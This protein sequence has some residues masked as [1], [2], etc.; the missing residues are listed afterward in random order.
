MNGLNRICKKLKIDC[1]PAVIGFDFHSGSSHPVYDG[2]VVCEEFAEIVTNAWVEEQEE[3]ERKEKEKYEERVYT[4][5][6]KLIRGL[7]L[8]EKLKSKYK[9]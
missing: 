9:F 5:W 3:I 1:A 8:R 2:F 7:L 4:N 6:K